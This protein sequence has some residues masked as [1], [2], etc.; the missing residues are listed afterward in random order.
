L[1]RLGIRTRLVGK[2]GDDFCG[3]ALREI[4]SAGADTQDGGLVTAPDVSTS[5]TVIISPPGVD[6]IFFHY[7]GANDTFGAGDIPFPEL[8]AARLFHFG[9]PP[10]M[11]RMYENSGRELAEIFRRAKN[12]GATTSLDMTFPDPDS[13]AG[14]AD[15]N[16][17]LAGVLPAVD[18]FMP[19]I[20]EI[21]FMLDRPTY[22]CLA[23]GGG[24]G[25]LLAAL[26][27]DVLAE[28]AG[29]LLDMGAGIVGLKLGS[30]GL[31]LKTAGRKRLD[32]AGRARP[33]DVKA[34]ADR[35]LW[36]P[37]FL[38]EVRGTTGAGDATIAGFLASLWH[39][40]SPE[41]AAVTAVAV[42]ACCVEAADALSGIRGWEETEKR[43]KAGWPRRMRPASRR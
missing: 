14:R 20:E 42:G 37:C 22:D 6:R 17:I 33:A 34:W 18:V 25:E 7:P 2:V 8:S 4:L 30:R 1:R 29:R 26:T 38:V 10:V 23:G 27:P 12:T 21:L 15:W 35:E 43:I 28:T 9:Y 40:L 32:T 3:R 16:A 19:S 5:Y 11:K 39:G 31:Y 13:A 41:K 24:P 36:T